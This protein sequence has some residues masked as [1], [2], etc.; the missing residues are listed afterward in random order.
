MISYY[1]KFLLSLTFA[2][3]IAVSSTSQASS[4]DCSSSLIVCVVPSAT[5]ICTDSVECFPGIISK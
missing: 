1:H 5:A 2:L 3:E 4:L